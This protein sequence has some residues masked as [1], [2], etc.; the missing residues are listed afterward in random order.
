M[1]VDNCPKK[2]SYR[3][4]INCRH[5]DFVIYNPVNGYTDFAIE[6]DDKS[7]ESERQIKSD[8]FK[9]MV[10]KKIGMPLIRIKAKPFYQPEELKKIIEEK[11]KQ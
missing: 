6:L 2:A 9:D 1:Y 11:L 10:F 7:H 5:V 8:R 4:K 3:K